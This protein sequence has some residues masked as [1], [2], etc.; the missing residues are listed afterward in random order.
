MLCASAAPS[1]KKFPQTLQWNKCKNNEYTHN[2]SASYIPTTRQWVCMFEL[3]VPLHY[4]CWA[5]YK[6]DLGMMVDRTELNQVHSSPGQSGSVGVHTVIQCVASGNNNDW[7][8]ELL[9]REYSQVAKLF[10]N[11]FTICYSMSVFSPCCVAP[12]GQKNQLLY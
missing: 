12:S 6:C 7:I 9:K 11:T 2:R 10:V 3:W 8:V 4:C 5:D 1:A